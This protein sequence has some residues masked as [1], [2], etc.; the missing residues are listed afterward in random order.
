MVDG[1]IRQDMIGIPAGGL[2]GQVLTKNSNSDYDVV[3]TTPTGGGGGS[4]YTF[5]SGLT[6][7]PLGT[8]KNDLI[9]GKAGGQTV[10]GGTASA[11]NLTL[12]STS[13]ATKGKILFGTSGNYVFDGANGRFGIGQ[14]TPLEMLHI[15]ANGGAD[16]GILIKNTGTGSGDTAAVKLQ[17]GGYFA[18]LF[19]GTSSGSGITGFYTQAPNGFGI[20]NSSVAV[21][22]QAKQS[23]EVDIP[24]GALVLG[25][26]NGGTYAPLNIPSGTLIGS[27]ANGNMEYNGTHLY[28]TIGTTRY[29]L[30]QQG[31]GG[32]ITLSGDVSGSGTT[33]ITTTI[34]T[35]KVL[36]TMLRQSAALSVIGRNVNTTG[37]AADIVASNDEHI[38][39]RSGTSLGFGQI[40]TG[41]ITDANVTYAKIQNVSATARVLSRYST[42]AGPMQEASLSNELSLST[43]GVMSVVMQMSITSDASGIKLSGDS[44]SPGNSMLYGTNGSGV[45]GWYAQPSGSGGL[46][47]AYSTITDGT[48]PASASGGDT[49]KLRSANSILSVVTANNDATHG[50][51]ALFTV[52]EANITIGNTTGQLNTSRINWTGSTSQYIQG[53]GSLATKDWLSNSTTSTQDGYFNT[54][55]LKDQVT[56]SHYL[57]IDVNENLTASRTLHIVTGDATR[58]LTFSGD[59]TISGT[60]TGDQTITLTSDVTGS[61]TGSFAT[62]IA[63]NVVTN[64]K[65]A[66]MAALSVKANNTNLTA[67]ATDLVASNDNEVL[68]RSGSAI[69]FG[70]IATGGITDAAVTYVKIQNV[71]T[72]TL[73]GRYAGTNGVAQEITIGSG[74][75]L[76]SS[77]GVLSATGGGS[78]T[79]TSVN[80]SVTASTA[81]SVSGGPITGSGT[82]AFTWTGSTSQYVRGDGSLLSFPSIPTASNYIVN[83]T[84]QQT[85]ANFNIDGAGTIGGLFKVGTGDTAAPFAEGSSASF[86]KDNATNSGTIYSH[87]T[88]QTAAATGTVFSRSTW[89][90]TSH[91][92]GAVNSFRNST[93]TYEHAGAGT[94]TDARNVT[95]QFTVNSATAG[96]IT[97]YK[98]FTTIVSAQP[99]AVG[100]IATYYGFFNEPVTGSGT[101]TITNRYA[102]YND[103]PNATSLLKGPLIL[104]SLGSVAPDRLMGLTFSTGDVSRVTL[105]TNLTFATNSINVVAPN[106]QL[107]YGVSNT[108]STSS[109]NATFDGTQLNITGNIYGHATYTNSTS[110]YQSVYGYSTFVASGSFTPSTGQVY[111]G[112]YSRQDWSFGT[113]THTV[114]NSVFYASHFVL[115][116]IGTTANTAVTM[117]TA[118]SPVGSRT[119]NRPLAGLTVQNQLDTAGAGITT[120]LGWAA[121]IYV[122]PLYQATGVTNSAKLTNYASLFIGD[123]QGQLQTGTWVTTAY[124]IY[125]ESTTDQ[126]LLNGSL[127]VN[128][129]VVLGAGTTTLA[130]LK[131]TSGTNLTTATAGV[132]EYDGKVM[133]F[134]GQANERGAVV[135]NQFITQTASFNGSNATGAQKWFNTTTNGAITL[136]AS[137]T[138]AFEGLLQLSR[139]AGTTSH[140]ISLQFGGTATLTSIGYQAVTTSNTGNVLT[141]TST[142]WIATPSAT[143]VT[144]ASISATENNVIYVRGL[145]RINAA[146]T[147]I[148]QFSFS[149]APGGVPTI[150]ANS[151]FRLTAIGSN[152]VGSLGNWS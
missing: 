132:T 17:N 74:L 92:S 124:A 82:L 42:G 148:P 142:L 47:N 73:L 37:N 59:A 115:N 34:G 152:T 109:A 69:A 139:T 99:S 41:G 8:V 35:N 134:T 39:R 87:K 64:A 3:W 81:L 65:L 110:G 91:A 136:S 38:L 52:T 121:G 50:D 28:F 10:I 24:T 79:V 78:G 13:H 112:V 125:Q 22:L 49:F 95:A 61:G 114:P 71:T 56:P 133:Y 96:T 129:G 144:A 118:S 111:T 16:K 117:S 147:L 116:V 80:A 127:T 113:A 25:N 97:V 101:L 106:N 1:T 150:A 46:T 45:K 86:L 6:E 60:N 103:D 70:Q 9:T 32:T 104:P 88:T 145:V 66:Q 100:T 23:G 141:A 140:T 44:A 102:F 83:S 76:N 146:G 67:N 36:D 68:R 138:Y 128:G 29:Q 4:T 14:G 12:Q 77:T 130:P 105:G 51:N 53:D 94:V 40:T 11:E 31:G 75:A 2:T 21:I 93:N 58:T 43:G 7:S 20:Y 137:T 30:D 108:S 149:A 55:K 54:I 143:V 107:I 84:S 27:P 131:F 126:S 18:T 19:L 62:T 5:T 26:S 135:S 48:T 89:A 151:W 33:S 63:N 123:V 122:A 119:L 57:T 85:S 98:G 72:Q 90:K 120:T 15:E